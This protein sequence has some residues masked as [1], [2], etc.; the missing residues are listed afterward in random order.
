LSFAILVFNHDREIPSVK[1]DNQFPTPKALSSS[2]KSDGSLALF[3]VLAVDVTG[4]PVLGTATPMT[5]VAIETAPPEACGMIAVCKPFGP[6]GS[7]LA[8][9]GYLSADQISAVSGA[10]PQDRDLILRAG[11]AELRLH[12]DGRVRLTGD[13]VT[14]E[15][16]G[17]MA[18]AGAYIELN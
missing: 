9:L 3:P 8:V 6:D 17:R 11:R 12:T 14:I 5:V 4:T 16:N 18:L 15:S 10:K 1:H 7:Q 13:S 2:G